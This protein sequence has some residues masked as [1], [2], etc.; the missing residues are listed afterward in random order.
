ML[1]SRRIN[2]SFSIAPVIW[3]LSQVIAD[4]EA[5]ST[6]RSKPAQ[7]SLALLIVG[8][9]CMLSNLFGSI[10]DRTFMRPSTACP[11][12]GFGREPFLTLLGCWYDRFISFSTNFFKSFI[13]NA[14]YG[15]PN[16]GISTSIERTVASTKGRI[17]G[18]R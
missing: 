18:D 9:S 6:T 8:R 11:Q 2:S 10:N 13:F 12:K 14:A 3:P 4:L 17:G 16:P 5:A 15:L 1:K 7:P